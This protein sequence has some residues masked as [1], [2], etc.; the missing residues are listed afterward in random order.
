[1][2]NMTFKLMMA[3]T[4]LGMVTGDAMAQ[5]RSDRDRREGADRR[6]GGAGKSTTLRSGV[7]LPV[8]CQ[9]TLGFRSRSCWCRPNKRNVRRRLRSERWGKRLNPRPETLTSSLTWGEGRHVVLLLGTNLQGRSYR[10]CADGPRSGQYMLR[11]GCV[12]RRNSELPG[13]ALL[14][15]YGT[16]G[17]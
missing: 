4:C 8:P 7:Q 5:D 10:G 2:K 11:P 13:L 12:L 16:P 9:E 1:M 6:E 17:S 15:R 3:A 14:G